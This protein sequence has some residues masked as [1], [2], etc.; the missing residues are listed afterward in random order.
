MAPTLSISPVKTEADWRRGAQLIIKSFGD[1]PIA[2]SMFGNDTPEDIERLAKQHQIGQE[3]HIKQ[4]PSVQPAIKCS[5]TE[6][7][8]TEVM[9]GFAEWFIHDRE[10]TEEEY[11]RENHVLRCEWVEDPTKQ[12]E[13]VDFMGGMV[14]ARQQLWK[15]RPYGLLM[16]MCVDEA[17]RRK[18]AATQ[19]VRWGMERCQELGIPAYLEATEQGMKAYKTMGWEV[20]QGTDMLFP[21]MVWWPEGVEKWDFKS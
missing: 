20:V 3:E 16:F 17:H 10:R 15:G 4:Y 9:V 14:A 19:C 18:G 11:T 6:A 13:C 7:D 8:G 12:K 21:G 1:L 2:P 5:Y